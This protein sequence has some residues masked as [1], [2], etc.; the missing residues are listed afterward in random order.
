MWLKTTQ[1]DQNFA[2]GKYNGGS[3][4]GWLLLVD[5]KK[6]QFDGRDGSGNY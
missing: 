1:A 4:V 3:D 2:I 5:N 6:A